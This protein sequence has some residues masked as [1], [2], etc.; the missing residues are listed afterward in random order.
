[1]VARVLLTSAGN[2]PSNNVARSLRAGLKSVRIFGC[3]DDRF[4]LKNSAADRNY[5]I[6]PSGHRQ[7]VRS[8]RH[9]VEAEAIQVIIPTVDADVSLLSQ[10]RRQLRSYLYLPN[11]S[12]LETCRDKYRLNARLGECGVDVP[13]T[14]PV[15]EVKDI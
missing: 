6:P 2:A 1:M 13:T 4:V 12:L 15:T 7:W 10:A 11:A 9:I 5:L 14:Y 8:L 3:H